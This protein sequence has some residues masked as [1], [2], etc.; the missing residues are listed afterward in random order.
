MV[1]NVIPYRLAGTILLH[2]AWKSVILCFCV[3][4]QPTAFFEHKGI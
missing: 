4:L 2:E 1:K 3:F